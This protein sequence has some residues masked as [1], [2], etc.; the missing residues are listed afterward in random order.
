MNPDEAFVV[1]GGSRDQ[2][3]HLHDDQ[4]LRVPL[5]KESAN[6]TGP[7]IGAM[8]QDAPREHSSSRIRNLVCD[9]SNEVEEEEEEISTNSPRHNSNGD[10]GNENEQNDDD[11]GNRN[12]SS[13]AVSFIPNPNEEEDDMNTSTLTTTNNNNNTNNTTAKEI[14]EIAVPALAGLAIDPFMTVMDTIFVGR[15]STNAAALAGMGT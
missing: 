4:L 11:N 7:D 10:N 13:S 8:K 3:E 12:A 1:E 5:L 14:L 6:D 15:T 9:N 2:G